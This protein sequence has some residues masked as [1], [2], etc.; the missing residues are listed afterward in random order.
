LIAAEQKRPDVATKRIFWRRSAVQFDAKR[1]VFL[2]ETWAKT[3]M[4][5]SHGR[6][7]Y[8]KRLF[9]PVPHGHWHTTTVLMG[10]RSDGIVSPLVVDGP[11][12]GR[13]FLAWV[14]QHLCSELRPKDIVVMD[15]LS[16]H[17]VAGVCEAIEKVGAEVR[18]LPPYSPDLNPIENLFS[19]FKSLLRTEAARTVRSLWSTVG[20]LI[21]KF[22]PTECLRYIL[23]AGYKLKS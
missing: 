19:K 2:D 23:N 9:E 22:S 5:R 14:Q 12:N 3:N 6:A 21:D 10:L 16:A 15:N 17:K 1:F 8:G 18:Y 11:I 4:V 13:I 7:L 20:R